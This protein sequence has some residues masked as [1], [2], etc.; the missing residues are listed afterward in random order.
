MPHEYTAKQQPGDGA[1]GKEIP[2]Q[3]H[4]KVFQHG[5]NPVGRQLCPASMGQK[6]GKQDGCCGAHGRTHHQ[7]GTAGDPYGVN[8]GTVLRTADQ[9]GQFVSDPVAPKVGKKEYKNPHIAGF[10][11]GVPKYLIGHL[12]KAALPERDIVYFHPIRHRN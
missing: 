9:G 10:Q 7:N 4:G 1:G 2:E 12:R 8:K 3:S 5:S 11:Q 6:N